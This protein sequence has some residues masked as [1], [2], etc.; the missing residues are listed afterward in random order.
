MTTVNIKSQATMCVTPLLIN[1][2]QGSIPVS[3]GWHLQE[4]EHN[5]RIGILF[6]KLFRPTV[7]KNCSCDRVEKNFEAEEQFFQT[8]KGQNNS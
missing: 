5:L 2:Y 1:Y 8:G 3:A 4:E 7:R 6:R